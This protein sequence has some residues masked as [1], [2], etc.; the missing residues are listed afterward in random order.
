MERVDCIVVG[1]GVVGL[2]VARE[3]QM[4][5]RSTFVLERESSFGRGTSS[6]NSEVIHAGIYY[7]PGSLKARLCV[8]GR[9]LLYD[10]VQRHGVAHSR[11]GKLIVAVDANDESKLQGYAQRAAANGV[12]DLR[13]IGREELRS[14]EPEVRGIAA[15]LSPST[16]IVDSHG[17]MAQLLNDLSVAGGEV[18]YRCNVT[19]LRRAGSGVAVD[20]PDGDSIQAR[21]VINAAGLQA[22]DLARELVSDALKLPPRN[23]FC[24]GHYY[25]L[26]GRAPFQ[27]LI[28]P[29]AVPGGLGVHVT[30]DLRQ[31]ARFG[32]DVRW[33]DAEDYDFDDSQRAAFVQAI[34]RYY[35]GLDP[36]RLSPAYT[37]IRPKVVGPGDADGDFCI[38][39]QRIGGDAAIVHLLG[40]ESPGLTSSLAIARMVADAL[41]ISPSN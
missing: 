18:V 26:T 33:V 31:Q 11:I 35:P 28:Y 21:Y 25:Q 32:P 41:A 15:L 16:G 27:R 5:G 4:R 40:I 6:R 7:T 24:K 36:E 14:L 13:W 19:G 1:A 38:D 22:P 23:A 37:G 10:Y 29:V 12:D 8:Q 20:L 3:L 30:L 17:L 9:H 34:Q 2:A 39:C